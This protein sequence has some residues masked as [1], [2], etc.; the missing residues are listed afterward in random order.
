MRLNINGLVVGDVKP[1]IITDFKSSVLGSMQ[2]TS[3]PIPQSNK[4]SFVSNYTKGIIWEVEMS[5]LASTH[6]ELLAYIQDLS[7]KLYSKP[8]TPISLIYYTDN[9]TDQ[10]TAQGYLVTD[11]SYTRQ[12][13]FAKVSFSILIPNGQ[14][15]KGNLNSITLSQTGVATGAVLPWTLPILLGSV[16]GAG[17]LNNTGNTYANVDIQI[18]GPGTGFTILN[19]TTGKNFKIEGLSLTAGQI[20]EVFGSTQTVNQQGVSIYQYVTS[21]SEFITLAQGNN[22]LAFYV[23]SGATS[24]TKA[25]ITWY[26][27]YVG[28]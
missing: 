3:Y 7:K 23:D 15:Y 2:T 21:T 28:I 1:Y 20:I 11:I 22:N 24:D 25:I 4:L 8:N 19:S 13:T 18:I 14:F 27:T 12:V 26:N 16:S 9:L 5:I 17:T 10:Y 6:E